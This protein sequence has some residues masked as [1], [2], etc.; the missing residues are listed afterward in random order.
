M[1]KS[2]AVDAISRSYC[3][4]MEMNSSGCA[5]SAQH[6]A[7]GCFD[8]A[9]CSIINAH[10][11]LH[12]KLLQRMMDNGEG[13]TGYEVLNCN[14]ALYRDDI[15]AAR[16][17]LNDDVEHVIACMYDAHP[18]VNEISTVTQNSITIHDWTLTRDQVEVSIANNGVDESI[19]RYQ[20]CAIYIIET[21]D[22]TPMELSAHF[23]KKRANIS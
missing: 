3:L 13:Y 20:A 11:E 1:T 17:A 9:I 7:F 15:D 2:E 4:M 6:A 16:R 19:E 18:Q 12:P 5:Y 10:P 14:S 23:H 21:Q 22:M 8:D